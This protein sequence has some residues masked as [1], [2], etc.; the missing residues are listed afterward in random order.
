VTVK[1]SLTVQ[2]IIIFEYVEIQSCEESF[3]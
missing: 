1:A 2:F 3:S